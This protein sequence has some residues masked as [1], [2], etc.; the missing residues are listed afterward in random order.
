MRTD[1]LLDVGIQIA[2]AL[3]AA[4]SKGIVPLSVPFFVVWLTEL[5][6]AF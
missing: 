6:I 5:R 3:D 2:N 4:H 1:E